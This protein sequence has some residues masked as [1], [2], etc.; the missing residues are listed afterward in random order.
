[1]KLKK[2]KKKVNSVHTHTQKNAFT[3]YFQWLRLPSKLIVFPEIGFWSPWKAVGLGAFAFF[4]FPLLL[5]FSL[6]LF[7]KVNFR[8]TE[9]YTWNSKI[10]T[11]QMNCGTK[12]VTCDLSPVPRIPVNSRFPLMGGRQISVWLFS[13]NLVPTCGGRQVG[14]QWFGGDRNN[15]TALRPGR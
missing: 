8:E 14:G 1:M 15:N 9:Q 2:K 3:I 12:S 4:F 7:L 6:S 13:A 5:S 10:S 11:V